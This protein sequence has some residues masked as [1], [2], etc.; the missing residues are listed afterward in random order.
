MHDI[1]YTFLSFEAQNKFLYE[2]SKPNT[3]EGRMPMCIAVEWCWGCV[4][5]V[6]HV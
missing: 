6:D 5:I 2:H 3:F 1:E 4:R